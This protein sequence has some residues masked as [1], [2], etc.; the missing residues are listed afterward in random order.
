MKNIM[1]FLI[2]TL[3][4]GCVKQDPSEQIAY[5]DGYWEIKS[6]TMPDG[7]KKEFKLSTTIDFIEVTAD[8]GMR[9][10]VSPQLDGSFL[11][12]NSVEKF[13]LKI[14]GDSLRMYYTTPFD[15]WKETV[16]EAKD[17]LLRVKNK[18]HKIYTY[19]RF[20]TFRIKQD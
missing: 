1:C 7:T 15:S 16:L 19:K 10:K 13:S 17:S 9:K 2:L 18:D 4:F 11:T 6:V 20:S 3:V 5:I 8:S 12:S 14:E